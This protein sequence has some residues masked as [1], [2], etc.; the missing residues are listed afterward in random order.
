MK[1]KRILWISLIAL[2]A[3]VTIGLFVIHIIML[4]NIVNKTPEQIASLTGFV[5]MLAT[6]TNLYLW[7][8]VV[9]TFV[10]LVAN[11]VGLV[12]Y[13]RKQTKKEMTQV[14]VDDLSEEQKEALRKE[15]FEDLSKK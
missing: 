7:A 6:N 10:I 1:N 8:F 2:D 5:G 11:V 9:P 3:I 15:L 4:A 12:I 13:V 14:N